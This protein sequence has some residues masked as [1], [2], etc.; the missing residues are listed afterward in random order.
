ME[1][2]L[3]QAVQKTR[4]LKSSKDIRNVFVRAGVLP[5]EY[6]SMLASPEVADMTAKQKRLFREF[7][8]TGTP[9]VYVNGRYRIENSAFRA[10][11]VEDFR[12]RYVA[13]MTSLLQEQTDK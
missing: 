5:S 7:G 2:L 3:F 12:K 6:D 10:D 13:A 11:S 8:V 4:E 1:S 9:S